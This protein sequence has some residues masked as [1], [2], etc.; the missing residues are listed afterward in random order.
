MFYVLDENKNLVEAFDKEGFLALLEQII[1][2]GSLENIDED[3]AVASKLRSLINGTTHHIE[4]VTQA[5]YNQLA[6]DEQLVAGTYY[7]IT[8]DD[9][10]EE[11]ADAIEALQTLTN[12]LQERLSA[13]ET[14]LHFD[15][16]GF[17]IVT[18]IT[19]GSY[20][21]QEDLTS[22]LYLAKIYDPTMPSHGYPFYTPLV[23]YYDGVN[24]LTT[25]IFHLAFWR[26]NTLMGINTYLTVNVNK[27]LIITQ[28]EGLQGP[29]N[30]IIALRKIGT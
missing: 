24:M 18:Q 11:F 9:T 20:T 19:D 3:T 14:N 15:D 4:F 29:I 1:E 21:T 5:Q 22:G 6:Q 28:Q 23:F 7:F 25:A 12:N 10:A 30:C 26:N 16:E 2:D 27:K 8:D 17:E 13:V